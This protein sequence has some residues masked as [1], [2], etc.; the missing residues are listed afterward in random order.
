MCNCISSRFLHIFLCTW[1]VPCFTNPLFLPFISYLPSDV[2]SYGHYF[3]NYI[4][5]MCEA[6][7]AVYICTLIKVE[8]CQF[9]IKILFVVLFHFWPS[10]TT[11][12][13]CTSGCDLWI[14][15]EPRN[16]CTFGIL[17]E[18][19]TL[20]EI[21]NSALLCL[22]SQLIEPRSGRAL[23]KVSK[24]FLGNLSV[25]GG[26][27]LTRE[28][29]QT[30]RSWTDKSRTL[31]S[32]DIQVPGHPCPRT[33]RS[34]DI[35]QVYLFPFRIWDNL[36]SVMYSQCAIPHGMFNFTHNALSV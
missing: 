17:R 14:C 1:L 26:G 21:E 11:F 12:Y 15:R 29:S 20:H 19:L 5:Q 10:G 7:A 27:D 31:R 6:S 35:L 13:P 3:D 30:S 25:K 22:L 24:T 36:V 9:S 32:L 33:S 8:L 34:P 16:Q 28:D 18:M 4:V 2:F 23:G